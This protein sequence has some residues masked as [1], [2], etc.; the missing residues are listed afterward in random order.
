M[1]NINRGIH[2]YTVQEA[3]NSSLPRLIEVT[4][5]MSATDNDDNDM[6]FNWVEIPNVSLQKGR[7]VRLVS[8]QCLD[9][10]VGLASM[11]LV[12]CRGSGT[13]GTAPTTAQRLGVAD[14]APDITA[15]EAEAIVV[16]G[17]LSLA[18]AFAEG[19][20]TSGVFAVT[21][22]LP[23]VI[24][25]A[26]ESTSL[27]VGGIYRSEPASSANTSINLFFGFEG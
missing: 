14:T 22:G 23:M 19:L 3:T 25:P 6:A 7:P 10:G 18:R 21:D 17:N 2:Q 8:V 13:A 27:Y 12:F 4:G 26:S 20:T 9:P 16:C 11:Q 5:T 1:A 24:A 15:A